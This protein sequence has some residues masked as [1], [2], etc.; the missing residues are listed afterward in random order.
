MRTTRISSVAATSTG[1]AGR[2]LPVLFAAA[3]AVA[4]M[5]LVLFAATGAAAAA[6]LGGLVFVVALP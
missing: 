3:A 5:L 4:R 2:M 1:I 6:A